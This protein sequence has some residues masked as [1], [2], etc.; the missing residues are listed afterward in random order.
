[1]TDDDVTKFIRDAFMG[2]FMR[3]ENWEEWKEENL[4]RLYSLPF[5]TLSQIR[6]NAEV[7]FM[8]GSSRNFVWSEENGIQLPQF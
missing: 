1:M 8:Y 5:Q 6:D 2:G 3:Q 7:A 4:V